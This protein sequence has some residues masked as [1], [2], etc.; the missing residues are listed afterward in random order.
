VDDRLDAA[1]A[2][3][4]NREPGRRHQRDTKGILDSYLFQ[5]SRAQR[6]SAAQRILYDSY[7][8]TLFRPILRV[9]RAGGAFGRRVAG[10]SAL[11]R[12]GLRAEHLSWR[13]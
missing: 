6:K 12:G 4:R 10:R 5:L 11:R 7:Y 2:L 8:I 3:G 13:N 9:T 1:V